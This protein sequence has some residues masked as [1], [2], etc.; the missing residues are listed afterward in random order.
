MKL[1]KEINIAFPKVF[2]LVRVKATVEAEIDMERVRHAFRM[3][4]AETT[5]Q[6]F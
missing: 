1:F 6:A 4:E 2:P 5:A 3:K